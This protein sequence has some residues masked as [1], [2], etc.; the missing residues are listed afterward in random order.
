MEKLDASE[1][2]HED[3]ITIPWRNQNKEDILIS[4]GLWLEDKDLTLAVSFF[5]SAADN[6]SLACWYL[7][8]IFI[9]QN[10][11][12]E[13]ILY[14]EK[15]IVIDPDLNNHQSLLYL[16]AKSYYGI[17]NFDLSKSFLDKIININPKNSAAISLLRIITEH[18]LN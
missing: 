10:N 4:I 1:A 9:K 2:D 6:S 18:R 13:A 7:G 3:S 11:Y 17:G 16:I 8:K 15:S 5:K 12:K 14:L